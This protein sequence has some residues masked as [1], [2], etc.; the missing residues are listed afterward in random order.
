MN[1]QNGSYKNQNKLSNHI[2]ANSRTQHNESKISNINSYYLNAGSLGNKKLEMCLIRDQYDPCIIGVAE[3][4]LDASCLD[5]EFFPNTYN[6]Y[7]NDRDRKGG[8]VC[9]AV[10]QYLNPA[11]I[12]VPN[13]PI[14]VEDIWVQLHLQEKIIVGCIYRPPRQATN[15]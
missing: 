6:V 8:G 3:T 7:R 9:I 1:T 12:T 2:N 5:G 4:H 11:R 13:G 10:K 14:K 15:C